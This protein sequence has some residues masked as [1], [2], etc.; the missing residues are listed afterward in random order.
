M[1]PSELRNG[2]QVHERI[3]CRGVGGRLPERDSPQQQPRDVAID[4]R[5]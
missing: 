5:P 3:P 2:E 4:I 1:L